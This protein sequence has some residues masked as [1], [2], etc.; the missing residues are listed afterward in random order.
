MPVSIANASTGG[1]NIF[2]MQLLLI[3]STTTICSAVGLGS[4]YGLSDV[5]NYICAVVDKF[6]ESNAS[7][8]AYYNQYYIAQ[9]VN[10]NCIVCASYFSINDGADNLCFDGCANYG[11]DLNYLERSVNLYSVGCGECALDEYQTI[12]VYP[13]PYLPS[14]F[15]KTCTATA[16]NGAACTSTEYFNSTS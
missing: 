9:G 14:I 6:Y 13:L 7:Y 8:S 11:T 16:T 3:N 10:N 15:L 1:Y 12:S 2:S 5:N 4:E